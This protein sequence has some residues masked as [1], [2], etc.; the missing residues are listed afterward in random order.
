VEIGFETMPDGSKDEPLDGL[1]EHFTAVEWEGVHSLSSARVRLMARERLQ[2]AL[3][4]REGLGL[5]QPPEL[6]IEIL[7]SGARPGR[8]PPRI[9]VAGKERPEFDLSLSHH[10]RFLA[11]VLFLPDTP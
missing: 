8:T 11:W 5:Q 6:P 10:G 7:T 4:A 3:A 1:R 9:R 2:I